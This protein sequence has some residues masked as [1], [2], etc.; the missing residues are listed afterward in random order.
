MQ[1]RAHIRA[2]PCCALPFLST[3]ESSSATVP[4]D[5]VINPKSGFWM[6]LVRQ[7]QTQGSGLGRRLIIRFLRPK[8]ANAL[9]PQDKPNRR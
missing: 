5:A 4:Q 7:R 6:R 1:P 3:N 2:T 9:R 8:A